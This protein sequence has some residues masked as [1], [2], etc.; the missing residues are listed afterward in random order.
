M[1]QQYEGSKLDKWLVS[2]IYT[3][4]ES[5]PVCWNARYTQVAEYVRYMEKR[6]HNRLLLYIRN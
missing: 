2:Y 4:K 1:L 6:K 3:E 5:F